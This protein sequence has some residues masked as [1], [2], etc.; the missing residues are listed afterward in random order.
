MYARNN[1][2]TAV[3]D[4]LRQEAG[5]WL[6]GYVVRWQMAHRGITVSTLYF[7]LRM[8]VHVLI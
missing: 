2:R 8:L 3:R 5:N 6:P 1:A 7:A 4:P